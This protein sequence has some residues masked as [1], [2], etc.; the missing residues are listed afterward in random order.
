MKYLIKEYRL[1][2]IANAIRRRTGIDREIIL[3]EMPELVNSILTND[4]YPNTLI[5]KDTDLLQYYIEEESLKAIANAIRN[6][7]ASA[8]LMTIDQMPDLIN[9]IWVKEPIIITY[10]ANGGIFA[11]NKTENTVM[12]NADMINFTQISKTSNVSEDGLTAD[13]ITGYGNGLNTTDT[14]TIENA[15]SLKVTITY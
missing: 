5:D 1:T 4:V 7:I 15:S 6:K 11:N 9:S 13:T 2:N 12:Y 8:D 10:N 3:S 14:I